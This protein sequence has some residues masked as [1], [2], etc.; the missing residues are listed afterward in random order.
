V[1]TSTPCPEFSATVS[2]VQALFLHWTDEVDVY[3]VG[4][5]SSAEPLAQ[6]TKKALCT[7]VFDP[8]TISLDLAPSNAIVVIDSIGR[9]HEVN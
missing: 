6:H 5:F 2:F 9:M 7:L 8:L 4:V 3:G 1:C